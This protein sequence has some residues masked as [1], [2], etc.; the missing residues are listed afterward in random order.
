M[1]QVRGTTTF[2]SEK[3]VRPLVR[4]YGFV[5]GVRRAFAVLGGLT[6]RRGR[7]RE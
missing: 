5:A 4:T 1:Q 2:V 6:R 7:R 3:A